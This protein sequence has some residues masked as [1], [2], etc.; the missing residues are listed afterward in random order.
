MESLLTES[1]M[2]THII[3]ARW[4]LSYNLLFNLASC[5]FKVQTTIMYVSPFGGTSAQ[6]T[7]YSKLL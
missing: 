2:S 7:L 1:D 4:L 6:P 5:S 3:C